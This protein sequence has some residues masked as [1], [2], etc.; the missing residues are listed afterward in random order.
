MLHKPDEWSLLHSMRRKDSRE[1]L[2]WLSCLTLPDP[3][4]TDAF[5]LNYYELFVFRAFHLWRSSE[6]WEQH[7]IGCRKLKYN[8]GNISFRL[9]VTFLNIWQELN[10]RIK[11]LSTFRCLWIFMYLLTITCFWFNDLKHVQ[12]GDGMNKINRLFY[13]TFP[14]IESDHR[15]L[16]PRGL[17]K[18][19]GEIKSSWLSQSALTH[20]LSSLLHLQEL[21]SPQANPCLHGPMKRVF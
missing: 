4:W 5:C 6:T 14:Q 17:K 20:Y 21:L 19:K 10:S 11:T 2:P 9:R 8:E 3:G 18:I 13:V 16:W 12:L 1:M 15:A 7:I